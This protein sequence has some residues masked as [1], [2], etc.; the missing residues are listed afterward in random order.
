MGTRVQGHMGTGVQ[1]HMVQV[2]T[3]QEGRS[4]QSGVSPGVL[5]SPQWCP[6]LGV[7]HLGGAFF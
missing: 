3:W 7:S 4:H 1:G 2:L 5:L 6:P